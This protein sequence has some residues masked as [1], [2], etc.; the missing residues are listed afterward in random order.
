MAI[1]SYRSSQLTLASAVLLTALVFA[2]IA[3]ASSG[4]PRFYSKYPKLEVAKFELMVDIGGYTHADCSLY[5]GNQRLGWRHIR[6]VGRVDKSGV[7]YRF[8]LVTTPL[9]CSRLGE[10]FTIPGVGTRKKTVIWPHYVF[11][12]KR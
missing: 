8:K 6:C 12:C 1:G 9:S 4:K 11:S 5:S 10:V 2:G 3:A 7:A